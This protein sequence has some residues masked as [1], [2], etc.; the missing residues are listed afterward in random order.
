MGNF[1][2][3]IFL[4]F[5][6]IF[7]LCSNLSAEKYKVEEIVNEK[8]LPN[9]TKIGSIV[10]IHS[11]KNMD[12]IMIA[13][14]GIYNEKLQSLRVPKTNSA[15]FAE[16]L[17]LLPKSELLKN[18]DKTDISVQ[19]ISVVMRSISKM[20]GM[21]YHFAEKK[22]GDVLYEKAYM[23]DNPQNKNKIP[24]QNT[25]SA[26]GQVSYC[27]QKDRT[28]GKNTYK[29]EYFQSENEILGTFLNEDGIGLLGIDAVK[30][31][32]LRIII[33][34][35]DCGDSI[36]LYLST[37]ANYKGIPLINMRNKIKESM[38]ERMD[39]VYRWFKVQF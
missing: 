38:L 20:E 26:D 25:G 37:D 29:L 28:F 31:H 14:S 9:L 5:S 4:I 35:F 15:F 8:V 12:K 36:L 1:M 10:A 21:R 30:A 23:I 3:K 18:S 11:D 34:I 33:N 22:G 39:A 6:S 17:Y 13:P 7:L 27:L 32:N 16:T 24:D 19:D 2:K